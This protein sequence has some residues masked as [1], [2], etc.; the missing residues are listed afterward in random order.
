MIE[1]TSGI[2]FEE[3]AVKEYEDLDPDKKRIY[4]VVATATALQL[5]LSK[6]DI[7]IA[8]RGQDNAILNALD[9]LVR[10]NIIVLSP[11]PNSTYRARQRELAELVER[12][13]Q[14][15]GEL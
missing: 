12:K 8:V 5:S 3:K 4:A 10:R 15:G 7:L 1:A 9:Q 14:A 6:K 2:R 11:V 13:L